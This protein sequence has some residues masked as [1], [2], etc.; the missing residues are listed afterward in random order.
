MSS[1]LVVQP[2]SIARAWRQAGGDGTWL[3]LRTKSGDLADVVIAAEKANALAE[4]RGD[5]DHAAAGVPVATPRGFA[6]SLLWASD[7][8]A[9]H[10][11]SED[12]AKALAERGLDGT[13]RGAAQASP[14]ACLAPS[15]PPTPTAFVVWVRDLPRMNDDPAK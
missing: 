7:R 6:V 3:E 5:G 1:A 15:L 14:T 9:V 12:F 11:W 8:A 2:A 13:L 10:R 4:A